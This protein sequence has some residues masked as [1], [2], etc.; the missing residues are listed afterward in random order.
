MPHKR[1]SHLDRLPLEAKPTKADAGLGLTT[2]VF[3]EVLHHRRRNDVPDAL[4]SLQRLERDAR[5]LA[6]VEGGAARVAAVDGGVDLN[7]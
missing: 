7:R 1:A 6:V 4:C 3:E 2:H 5:D